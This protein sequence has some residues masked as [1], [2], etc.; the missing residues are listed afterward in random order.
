M[1]PLITI[2][3]IDDDLMGL[4]GKALWFEVKS[5]VR[6]LVTAASVA[7]FLAADP[8]PG[9]VTLDLNLGN[10]TLPADNVRALVGAGHKVV[11]VT[12]VPEKRWIIETT[13]A[14]A[15]A[16]LTS[17]AC[18]LGKLV[19][20]IRALDR[21]ELPTT[22]EHAFWLAQDDRPDK[23][24]LTPTESQVLRLVGDGIKQESVGRRLGMARSTVATHLTNIRGKYGDSG[25]PYAGAADY[26][27]WAKQQE[28]DRDRHDPA[29]GQAPAPDVEP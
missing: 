24:R 3:A 11:I 27:D 4:E 28:L 16:Y 6:V 12:V 13:E 8:P 14:G 20:V 15:S 19:D 9:I 26:R 23:P 10:G 29:K 21:G 18:N 5:N 2:G 1:D 25:L 17:R 7:E 22:A